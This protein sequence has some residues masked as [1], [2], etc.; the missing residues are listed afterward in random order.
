MSDSERTETVEAEAVPPFATREL[1][2]ATVVGGRYE[3][4]A[5]LGS[6]GYAAVYRARDRELR[7]EVALKVLHPDRHTP[8][9]LLRLRREVAVARDASSPRLVRI[10]DIGTSPEGV[11]LTMEVLGGSLKDRLRDG[12]LP[13]TE[14]VRIAAE[15]LEGLAAL[16]AL[17]IVHRDVKPA[18]VLLTASGEV[19]LADFGLARH[20]DRDETRATLNRALIGTV[21]YLSPEQALGGEA[22]PRSDLYAAG[23]VLYEMLAGRLPF[24]AKSDLGALLAHLRTPPPDLC[25][26][27]PE[28]PRWLARIV[29]R[30]L[31]KRPEDRHPQAAAA[32]AELRARRAARR[33]RRSVVRSLVA[34]FGV[35][36]VAGGI[37]VGARSLSPPRAEYSYLVQER[38][39]FAAIGKRGQKLWAMRGFDPDTTI[40]TAPARLDPGGPRLLATVLQRP[41][42]WRP[43]QVSTL[44][45]LD[46]ETGRVVKQVRLPLASEVF[47]N[48]PQRFSVQHVVAVDLYGDGRDEVL[49]SYGHVPEAPSFT[50][51]Y[52]PR[53]DRAGIV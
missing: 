52:A 31:A 5:L 30:L 44:S 19:K 6:G 22:D 8:G 7:R 28:V 24:P 32:L 4:I 49:V 20:L 47:P 21:D 13:I 50:V 38:D 10:F 11:Y 53:L 3:L 29:C 26:L 1:A 15:L 34:G 12:A 35:V 42:Q 40:R 9:A 2:P 46:P 14:A 23:L 43:D 37:M 27:R 17:A 48:D 25:R 33:P 45:Y 16:H 39:G 41:A 18:N 36:G 51:L